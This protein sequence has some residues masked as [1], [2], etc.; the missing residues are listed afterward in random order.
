MKSPCKEISAKGKLVSFEVK[1]LKI[2]LHSQRSSKSDKQ[3]R[4]I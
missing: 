1:I 4:R 3:H 2:I